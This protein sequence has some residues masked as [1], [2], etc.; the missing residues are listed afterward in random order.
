MEYY[1]NYELWKFVCLQWSRG[2]LVKKP[3]L[4]VGKRTFSLA[5]S[6]R[7]F[8]LLH[9]PTLSNNLL[10]KGAD[11]SSLAGNLLERTTVKYLLYLFGVLGSLRCPWG[12]SFDKIPARTVYLVAL[13]ALLCLSSLALH[14]RPWWHPRS[15]PFLHLQSSCFLVVVE[16]PR[17][18]IPTIH[19]YL[20]KRRSRASSR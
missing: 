15:G 16:M 10:T 20:E 11:V 17:Q 13:C 9:S 12:A 3:A 5:F 14:I 6:Q 8:V 1:N 19:T 4:L 18:I 2:N 7:Q